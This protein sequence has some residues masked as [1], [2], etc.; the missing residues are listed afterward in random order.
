[1]DSVAA[2][3]RTASGAPLDSNGR[4][5]APLF[6]PFTL[7]GLSLANRIV[8]SPMCQYSA[9]DGRVG[10]WHLV[11]LGSRAVGGAGLV[12]TEM[13]NVSAD[14]R[15]TPGCAGLYRPDHRDAWA[16]IV[17]FI[18]AQTG[19]KVGIQLAHAGRK[20]SM[21]RPWDAAQT[22]LSE[23]QGGWETIGPSPVPFAPGYA[24]P[25]E[26]SR[27]DM[28]RVCAAF[29]RAAGWAHEAGF[30]LLEL[31]AAHGYLLSSYLSPASNTRTDRYGGSLEGR[32]R[33]PLEVLDAVRGVWPEEKPVSVRITASDWLE[34]GRGLTPADAV[35]IARALKE[36]GCDIVDVS[37][38]GNVPESNPIYGRMYQVPFAERIRYEAGIP[39]IAVGGLH[40]PDHA[41]TVIAAGRADLCA[42]ARAHLADPYLTLHAAEQADFPDQAWPRQYLSARGFPPGPKA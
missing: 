32:M 17:G 38:G 8:V 4:P 42:L 11:H 35:E 12:M 37:S 31:H 24:H 19:A 7:R 22:A 2:W 40:G 3:N 33:F 15:I 36:H 18:H 23:E 34:E 41:N 1:V 21:P 26:M 25:R 16:R 29:A 9:E 20:A 28:D 6:T 39:V 27:A 13:T 10:D 14:G 5:P 30:D